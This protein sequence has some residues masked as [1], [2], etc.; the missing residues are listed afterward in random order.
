M[1]SVQAF[2]KGCL[3]DAFNTHDTNADKMLDYDEFLELS[4]TGLGL[5]FEEGEAETLFKKVDRNHDG[6]ISL[7]E[8]LT[9]FSKSHNEEDGGVMPA[10][11]RIAL[12][13]HDKF[14]GQMVSWIFKYFN[15]SYCNL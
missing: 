4:T 8:L 14:K 5:H 1:S 9:Y 10:Q 3:S 13:A 7:D 11:K 12:V 2:D 6:K 15:G